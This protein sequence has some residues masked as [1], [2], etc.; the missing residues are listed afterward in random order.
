MST[1]KL[2]ELPKNKKAVV[3]NITA[4]STLGSRL[5]ELG[6]I[7]DSKIEIVSKMF[8][9]GSIVVAIRQSMIALRKD[10]AAQ[11]EVELV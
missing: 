1:I 5:L 9:G 4:H 10:D 6:I 7:P 2:N 3:K 8:F 11:I